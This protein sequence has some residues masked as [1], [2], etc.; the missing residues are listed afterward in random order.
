MNS[1]ADTFSEDDAGVFLSIEKR[2]TL[3]AL[4]ASDFNISKAAEALGVN[5]NTLSARIETW[6]LHKLFP[7]APEQNAVPLIGKGYKLLGKSGWTA[8]KQMLIVSALE[9]NNQHRT[10]TAEELG[11]SLRSLAIN[12][13][14][15]RAKGINI[16]QPPAP[17]GFGPREPSYDLEAD[18]ELILKQIYKITVMARK[19]G[20]RIVDMSVLISMDRR[21]RAGIIRNVM[22]LLCCKPAHKRGYL[23]LSILRSIPMALRGLKNMENE[24]EDNVV[25]LRK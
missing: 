20:D 12:I 1:T 6:G 10:K 14:T 24:G 16:P 25:E 2:V 9:R 23:T 7:P 13:N 17:A 8:H 5:R 19:K 22:R 15:L 11:I 4:R 18:L 3:I 21:L